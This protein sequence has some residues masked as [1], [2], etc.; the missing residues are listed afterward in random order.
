VEE[1]I[2]QVHTDRAWE[3]DGRPPVKLWEFMLDLIYTG[4]ATATWQFF[5]KAWVPGVPGKTEFLAEFR[6]ELTKSQY[7]ED[8]GSLVGDIR[9]WGTPNEAK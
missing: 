2:R 1:Q 9:V 3:E 7:W 8:L 4:N 6:S 5:E